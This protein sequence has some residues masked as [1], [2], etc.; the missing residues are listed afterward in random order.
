VL[1]KESGRWRVLSVTGPKGGVSTDAGKKKIPADDELRRLATATLLDFARAVKLKDFTEF[2]GRAST[3]L[4]QHKTAAEFQQAFHEFMDKK[5][6]ISG[7]KETQPVLDEPP[8]L[9]AD[10]A[11]VL[12]GYYPTKPARVKF[13][14]Q[15]LYEHPAWKLSSIN[16]T[17][18]GGE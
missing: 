18:E 15:Y 12:S 1:V 11:L 8:A 5:I 9:D 3:P 13:K 10:G 16:I 4:R 6:D 7:V 17:T 14:L 2:H